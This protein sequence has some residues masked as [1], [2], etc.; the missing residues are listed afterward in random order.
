MSRALHVA[1]VG[2]LALGTPAGFASTTAKPAYA[3]DG[4][5]EFL[6]PVT[7]EW[8]YCCAPYTN[9]FGS[10]SLRAEDARL[11]LGSAQTARNVTRLFDR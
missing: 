5:M 4:C 6:N 3:G 9:C 10:G 1:A 2:A 7:K 11:L 8:V